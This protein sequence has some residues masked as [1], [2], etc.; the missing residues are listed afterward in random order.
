M[1]LNTEPKGSSKLIFLF[2]NGIAG[3]G[4]RQQR[5]VPPLKFTV[6]TLLGP[7]LNLQRYTILQTF[8]F[9]TANQNFSKSPPQK[10]PFQPI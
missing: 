6:E 7:N 4:G 3:L 10:N 2:A 9:A 8:F 5:Q 1:I